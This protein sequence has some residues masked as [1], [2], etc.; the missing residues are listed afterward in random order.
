M[1]KA[2]FIQEYVL[3]RRGRFEAN[4]LEAEK[5]YM[6]LSQK[7][8]GDPSLVLKPARTMT[9]KDGNAYALIT[10]DGNSYTL[11][12]SATRGSDD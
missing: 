8:Y 12:E 1:D 9:D 7:G 11:N 4:V 2:R 10:G 6:Y 3:D 5:A